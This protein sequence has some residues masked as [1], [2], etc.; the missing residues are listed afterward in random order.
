MH[1]VGDVTRWK[2]LFSQVAC[3]S[4]VASMNSFM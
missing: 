2:V 3:S 1:E 4:G